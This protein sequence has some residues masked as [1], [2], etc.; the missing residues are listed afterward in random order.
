MKQNFPL[1][2]ITTETKVF[3]VI[4]NFIVIDLIVEENMTFEWNMSTLERLLV[5][6]KHAYSWHAAKLETFQ[7]LA[8]N[9][10]SVPVNS[11]WMT[12]YWWMRAVIHTDSPTITRCSFHTTGRNLFHDACFTKWWTVSEHET[13]TDWI[14]REVHH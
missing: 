2:K 8:E 4:D 9:N 12:E 1:F 6:T 3:E 14:L 11:K 10:Y 7:T 13:I 5:S